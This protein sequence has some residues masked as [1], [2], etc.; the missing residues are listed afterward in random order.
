M[1]S[2]Q[3]LFFLSRNHY[4]ATILDGLAGDCTH[5]LS[6]LFFCTRAVECGLG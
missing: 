3:S 1:G 6:L 4:S 5:D 2:H